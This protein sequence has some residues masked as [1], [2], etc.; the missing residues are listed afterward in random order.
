MIFVLYTGTARR[1]RE[2]ELRSTSRQRRAVPVYKT[3]IILISHTP[4]N[5]NENLSLIDQAWFQSPPPS[6]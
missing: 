1:C 2:I 5:L 4:S 3:K 6:W